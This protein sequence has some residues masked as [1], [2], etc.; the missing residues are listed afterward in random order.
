MLHDLKTKYNTCLSDVLL[1]EIETIKTSLEANKAEKSV[2]FARQRMYE[3]ANKPNKNL[4][5][6]LRSRSQAQVI[7]SMKDK[8]GK[9]HHDNK[10]INKIFRAFYKRL[11]SLY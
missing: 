5:N 11:Y 1:A 10:V 2:F 6:L 3:F 8:E 9:C 7:S 4:A